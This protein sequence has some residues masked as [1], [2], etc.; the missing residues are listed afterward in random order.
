MD[1]VYSKSLR[2]RISAL[3][4]IPGGASAVAVG[5][6]TG[7]WLLTIPAFVVLFVGLWLFAERGD[8]IWSR[9]RKR[10]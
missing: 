9:L 8:R 10:R 7:V 5:S 1:L 2:R 6:G 4:W 3:L